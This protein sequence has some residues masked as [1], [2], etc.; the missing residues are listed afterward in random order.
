V[1]FHEVYYEEVGLFSSISSS[2]FA[3]WRLCRGA[4]LCI[5]GYLATFI[6][7]MPWVAAADSKFKDFF[8]RGLFENS[9]AAGFRRLDYFGKNCTRGFRGSR[10]GI[11]TI[12]CIHNLTSLIYLGMKIQNVGG[13]FI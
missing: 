1:G 12:N 10:A 4:G 7:K 11:N 2:F 6:S 3:P 13:G 9:A 8:R 5:W